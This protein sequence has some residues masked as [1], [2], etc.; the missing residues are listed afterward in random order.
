MSEKKQINIDMRLFD[1]KNKTQKKKS[2]SEKTNEIKIKN[3]S[4]KKKN[5]S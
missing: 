1:N 5:E 2:L 3:P 4:P